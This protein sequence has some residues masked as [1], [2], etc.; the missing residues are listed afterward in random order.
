[1]ADMHILFAAALAI[2]LVNFVL[3][4]FPRRR[5]SGGQPCDHPAR[6]VVNPGVNAKKAEIVM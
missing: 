6:A 2:L 1:M 5:L 3:V 4:F